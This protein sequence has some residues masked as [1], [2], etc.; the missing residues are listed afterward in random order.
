MA[1]RLYSYQKEKFGSIADLCEECSDLDS[2]VLVPVS[3]CPEAQ[4]DADRYY[5]AMYSDYIDVLIERG[6]NN[7]EERGST[8]A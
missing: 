4:E 7:A 3:F 6:K 2:G 1:H 8:P 5:E